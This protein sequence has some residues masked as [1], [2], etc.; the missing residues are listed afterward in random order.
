MIFYFTI[1]HISIISRTSDHFAH[2]SL[3]LSLSPSL[4]SK[5]LPGRLCF[6]RTIASVS[7]DA[8]R[9]SLCWRKELSCLFLRDESALTY[10]FCDLSCDRQYPADNGNVSQSGFGLY[11]LL[12]V[13]WQLVLHNHHR[14]KKREYL[15]RENLNKAIRWIEIKFLCSVLIFESQFRIS[16][17]FSKIFVKILIIF[18]YYVWLNF[19]F[20]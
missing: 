1:N 9:A 5:L 2:V 12:S 8:R 6:A 14:Y 18:S 17:S 15:K 10:L 16:I 7:H 20:L 11:L 13:N 19:L 4:I 3:S